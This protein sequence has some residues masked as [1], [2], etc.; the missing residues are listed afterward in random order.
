MQQYRILS[1]TNFELANA[2]IW[3]TS[4]GHVNLCFANKP[5]TH[6]FELTTSQGIP[7]HTIKVLIDDGMLKL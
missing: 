4:T 5:K 1:C 2:R 7:S 6:E 3:E